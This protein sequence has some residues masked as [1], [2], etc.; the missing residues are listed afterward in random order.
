MGNT[1]KEKRTCSGLWRFACYKSKIGARWDM[2]NYPAY[3][4]ETCSL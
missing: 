3:S 4:R 2:P 1:S